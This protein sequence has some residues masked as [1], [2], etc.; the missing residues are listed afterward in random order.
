MV[1]GGSPGLK[2]SWTVTGVRNDAYVRAYPKPVEQDKPAELVGKYLHPQL[3]GQPETLG[4]F[5][6]P[7][8]ANEVGV[9]SMPTGAQSEAPAFALPE[10]VVP[11]SPVNQTH[12]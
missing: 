2:V 1:A 4:I 12:K 8:I 7:S 9:A 3:F 6:K 5:Y 10:P 11:A